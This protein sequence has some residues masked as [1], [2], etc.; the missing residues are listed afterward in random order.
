M[1]SPKGINILL[2][3]EEMLQNI[4]FSEENVARIANAG[5]FDSLIIGQITMIFM[6]SAG[7]STVV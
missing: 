6:N 3:R 1:K 5:Q 2:P 4:L 7:L